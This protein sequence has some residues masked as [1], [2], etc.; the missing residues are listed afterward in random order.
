DVARIFETRDPQQKVSPPP[1]LRE[2]LVVAAGP[3]VD[4]RQQAAIG[5][6]RGGERIADADDRSRHLPHQHRHEHAWA[7]VELRRDSLTIGDQ[8][9]LLFPPLEAA[10]AYF[11]GLRRRC[12]EVPFSGATTC[13]VA[14]TAASGSSRAKQEPTPSSVR[15]SVSVPLF[16][17]AR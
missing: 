11:A 2:D 1:F 9:A 14:L 6:R 17:S 5:A 15:S 12:L 4:E 16:T 13:C 8:C 7:G 10:C 3:N